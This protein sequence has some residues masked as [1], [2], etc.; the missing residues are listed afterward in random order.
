[1]YALFKD[2]R[3]YSKAHSTKEAAA[4]E[5]Y[6]K[7]VIVDWGTDFPSD[8][9]GRGIMEGFEIRKINDSKVQEGK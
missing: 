5:A 8:K 2:G 4:I 1:M 9:P 6:E 7:G 3:Q